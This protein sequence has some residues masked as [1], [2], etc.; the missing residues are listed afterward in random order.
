MKPIPV[1]VSNNFLND[2]YNVKI[3]LFTGLLQLRH[4]YHTRRTLTGLRAVL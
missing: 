3:R 1:G 2:I 4:I